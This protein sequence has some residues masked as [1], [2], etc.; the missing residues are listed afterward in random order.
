LEIQERKNTEAK[1]E[2]THKQLVDTSRRAGMAEVATGVLHNVG[3]VLNSVN[4]SCAVISDKISGSRV[5]NVIKTADLLKQHGKDLANFLTTDPAGQKLP[6]YLGKLGEKLTEDHGAVL[7]EIELL[8]E[9]I[10]HIKEVIAVQQ[11]HAHARGIREILSVKDMVEDA[12]RMNSMSMNRHHVEVIREYEEV[13]PVNLE[14]HKVLQIL[15]NIVNNAKHALTDSEREDKHIIVRIARNDGHIDV[16]VRD[17]GIGIPAENLTRIF[18]HGFT[19]KKNGHG[20]GLHSGVLAAKEIGGQLKAHSEG[21]GRG[22]TFTL[23]LPL[24]SF[25]E[26]PAVS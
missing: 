4:I 5:G 2:E 8:N 22:A 1:L 14:K 10:E 6:D 24:E 19:T 3:N 18:T 7:G 21:Q 16:S 25:E 12:L 23:E 13:P 20:F 9:N 17:N 11:D 26:Q 15:V